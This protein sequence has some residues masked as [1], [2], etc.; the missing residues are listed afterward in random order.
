MT[1]RPN[2]RPVIS[3]GLE[4]LKS[5]SPRP[6]VWQLGFARM[7]SWVTGERDKPFR[8]LIALCHSAAA[9]KVGN[10]DMCAP[11][12][13]LGPAAIAAVAQLAV[14]RSVGYRPQRIEVRDAQ[15]ADAVRADLASCGIEVDMVERLEALDEVIADMMWHVGGK[16]A[17][18]RFFEPGV[19]IACLRAFAEAAVELQRAAPW[20]FL[21][22]D[23]LVQ[24]DSPAA[25][26]GLGCF[27][28]LGAGGIERGLGFFPSKSAFER[29]KQSEPLDPKI[30]AAGLWLM[31]F[32]EI[33]DWP[34]ADSELWEAHD[35]PVAGERGYP[36][37]VCHLPNGG[38]KPA[39]AEH[40]AFV[41]ALLRALAATTEDEL[42]S[43]RWTRA[44]ETSEGP[45]EV[46]L[47]LPAVL[48]AKAGALR[49]PTGGGEIPDRRVMEKTLRDLQQLMSS[50]EFESTEELNAF[51]A[52][53]SG[54]VPRHAPGRTPQDKAQELVERAFEERGRMRIKL[55]R[56]ALRLWPDCAEA[57]V[58]QA[59]QMPDLERRRDLY[60]N[61]LE[62]AERALGPKPFVEDVGHFWGVLETRPYM[63]TRNG[64]A[65]A[66]W[67]TGQRDEAIGHW[68]DMLR[69]CPGDNLGVRQMLVPRLLEARRDAEAEAVLAQYEEDATAMLGYAR[70]LLEFR[71]SGSGPAAK[72]KL[73]A[74]MRRNAYVPKYLTGR[75][76]PKGPLPDS[77]SLGSDDEAR[78]ATAVLLMAW[79]S[80]EG[81]I[82]WL[83]RSIRPPKR[84]R[85]EQR[86]NRKGK[87]GR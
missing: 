9:D 22:D 18:A 58:L 71:R 75:A 56:E 73:D 39:S 78:I 3:L 2:P 29:F 45:I 42:D 15:L 74:A 76:N 53:T 12:D 36:S 55:A 80:T 19:D 86:S 49:R 77:Y 16:A 48:E 13:P 31:S 33:M 83:G 25:P 32:D 11:G 43:G 21:I 10:G 34:I 62:A 8:P 26:K 23:D 5:L 59:E 69:L 79:A 84:E 65:G 66:L 7:P 68:L 60:R 47:S 54:E 17:S 40:L 61:G 51:L 1:T 85:R 52:K 6:D 30:A 38:A 81:A 72:A 82:E 63:R 70:V 50:R 28:V 27:N 46:E 24:V 35:L 67:D 87:K 64:L 20:N 57:W 14:S 37:L 44:V 4:R 41:Q